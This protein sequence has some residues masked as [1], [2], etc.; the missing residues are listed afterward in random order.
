MAITLRSTKGSELTH[1]ELDQNFIDLRDGVNIMVPKDQNS[2]IRVDSTGTPTYPW[3]D[4]RSTLYADHAN[5]GT[6]PTFAV[7][8]G[9]LRARQFDVADEAYIEFHIPHDYVMGS[10]LFIH[11][12]WSHNDNGVTGGT[13]TWGFE[14]TYAKGHNQAAFPAPI[15]VSVTQAASLT[16]Y[17]HMIAETSITSVS[18]SSTS[19]VVGDIEVDGLIMVRVWLDS[20][21]ITSTNPQ[22]APFLHFVD[23]HYQSTNIGTKN[24][25]PG[26]WS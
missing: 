15:L 17:Q 20:N 21:N 25:S 24:K 13:V 14:I 6:E 8:R 2:G 11:N 16:Q 22:P 3:H 23:I 1:N 7:Y 10:E 4:L 18:G 9:G 5:P 19:L 12:H 26:F